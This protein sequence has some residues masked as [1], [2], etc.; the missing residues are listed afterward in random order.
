MEG[1]KEFIDDM[2]EAMRSRGVLSIRHVGETAMLRCS[3]DDVPFRKFKGIKGGER[4][5]SHGCPRCRRV[6][7]WNTDVPE[8]AEYFELRGGEQK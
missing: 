8:P 1:I 7:M 5:V 2:V 3:R 4:F 6:S